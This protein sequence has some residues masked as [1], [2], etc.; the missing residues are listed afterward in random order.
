[1]KTHD[2]DIGLLNSHVEN[3]AQKIGA[4]TAKQKI[5]AAVSEKLASELHSLREVQ[6]Q[7]LKQ[8]RDIEAHQSGLYI[9][10]NIGE[11]G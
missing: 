9:W 2:E 3:V 10:E 6:L 8:I 7:A 1:M 5:A 11:G 4:L